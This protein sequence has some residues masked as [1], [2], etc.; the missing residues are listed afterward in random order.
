ML[1]L[2]QVAAD[3]ERV[4]TKYPDLA[5]EAEMMERTLAKFDTLF[6]CS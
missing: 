2:L 6:I 1:Y 4:S 3:M 5:T